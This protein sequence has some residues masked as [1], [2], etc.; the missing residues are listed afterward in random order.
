V[1]IVECISCDQR[2]TQYLGA[3]NLL[4]FFQIALRTYRRCH[5]FLLDIST[6]QATMKTLAVLFTLLAA[7]AASNDAAPNATSTSSTTTTTTS[8]VGPIRSIMI[9]LSSM[10]GGSSQKPRSSLSVSLSPMSSSTLISSLAH[11]PG[12]KPLRMSRRRQ[13]WFKEPAMSTRLCFFYPMSRNIGLRTLLGSALAF[14]LRSCY[15]DS[16]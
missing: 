13:W 1:R 2:S 4:S 8:Y 5:S 16:T 9:G 6:S 12:S 11:L 3:P 15:T 10:M 14:A 7:A